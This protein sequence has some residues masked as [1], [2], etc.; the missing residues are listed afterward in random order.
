VGNEAQ[1]LRSQHHP[2]RW[3]VGSDDPTSQQRELGG[4]RSRGLLSEVRTQRSRRLRQV[5]VQR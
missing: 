3:A 2:A 4:A 1:V 5:V